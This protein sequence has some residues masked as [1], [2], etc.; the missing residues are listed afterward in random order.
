MQLIASRTYAFIDSRSLIERLARDTLFRNGVDEFL[1]HMATHD[2]VEEDDRLI[3]L[4]CR[5]ALLW[6]NEPIE[7]FGIEWQ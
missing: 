4:N 7:E 3:R 1:L 2:S 5:A 6:I